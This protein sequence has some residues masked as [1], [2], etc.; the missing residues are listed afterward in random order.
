MYKVMFKANCEAVKPPMFS[1]RSCVQ[2]INICLFDIR[3]ALTCDPR[4]PHT[5]VTSFPPLTECF[6]L[7]MHTSPSLPP[8]LS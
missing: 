3:P 8:A 1:P 6:S 4:C 2:K 5:S 7:P